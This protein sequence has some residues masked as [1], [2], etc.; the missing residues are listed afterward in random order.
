[1]LL[2]GCAAF[3]AAGVWFLRDDD[4][5]TRF[6]GVLGIAVFGGR[7]LH[8]IVIKM[9]HPLVIIAPEGVT[10]PWAGG[11]EFIP[12]ENIEK[13]EIVEHTTR[14]GP[15]GTHKQKY[16]G[17]FVFDKTGVRGAGKRSQAISRVV[18]NMRNPPAALIH[19]GLSSFEIE[20][21][22]GILQEHHDAYWGVPGE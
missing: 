5:M 2:L 16:I 20:E 18:L 14:L 19:L 4:M 11:K 9:R 13:F 12:W 7:G 21:V 17:V 15:A 10:V 6:I 3:V 8:H 1:L 22:L